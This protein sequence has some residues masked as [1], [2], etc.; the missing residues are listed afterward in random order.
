MDAV[1]FSCAKSFKEGD[2]TSSDSGGM[3]GTRVVMV[4]KIEW[5]G[6]LSNRSR[7]FQ[8][9]KKVYCLEQKSRI[10]TSLL[11]STT[12]RTG[13]VSAIEKIEKIAF[14][15]LIMFIYLS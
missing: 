12:S 1:A 5:L 13:N 4:G 2:V 10:W 8:M 3:S 11:T 15:L 9:T 7:C 14:R 6:I